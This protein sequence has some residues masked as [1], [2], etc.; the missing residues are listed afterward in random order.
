DSECVGQRRLQVANHAVLEVQRGH[1]AERDSD[2][3]DVLPVDDQAAHAD[4]VAGAGVDVDPEPSGVDQ[5]AR[6]ARPVIGYVDGF[7]DYHVAIAARGE[8]ADLPA[9]GDDVVRMLE[10]E[11]GRA[12]GAAGEAVGSVVGDS[13]LRQW[14]GRGGHCVQ[15]GHER[16]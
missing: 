7:G 16:S 11:T 13:H 6:L 15:Q 3:P 12:D 8:Y 1:D 9:G 5:D 10:G 2:L 4:D 14:G